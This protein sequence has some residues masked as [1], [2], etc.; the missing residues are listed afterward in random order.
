VSLYSQIFFRY[1]KNKNRAYKTTVW[2]SFQT[3]NSHY[4]IE[5]DGSSKTFDTKLHSQAKD[6]MS[7]EDTSSIILS[8]CLLLE[9]LISDFI[10]TGGG[11]WLCSIVLILAT[12]EFFCSFY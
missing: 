1:L 12:F 4:F 9:L 2:R 5:E 3:E 11:S 7:L 10:S 8:L 6:S